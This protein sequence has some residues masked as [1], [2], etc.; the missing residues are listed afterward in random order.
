MYSH[1]W[2]AC[3][4][5]LSL[6]P[7]LISV[8]LIYYLH[9][10]RN[11]FKRKYSIFYP[12]LSPLSVLA[13]AIYACLCSGAELNI[14][15]TDHVISRLTREAI[16]SASLASF[17]SVGWRFQLIGMLTGSYPDNGSCLSCTLPQVMQ[18]Y[19]IK[20]GPKYIIYVP[21]VDSMAFHYD[22]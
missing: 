13:Q 19:A 16:E 20:P 11:G 18:H 21:I 12:P 3:F 8:C 6:P 2:P 22:H 15:G 14:L 9:K 7:V 17:F 1:Q 10:S 5:F 4:L